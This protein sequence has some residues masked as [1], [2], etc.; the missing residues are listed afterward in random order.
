MTE[1][2][3]TV[4]ADM[5][6][7]ERERYE[8]LLIELGELR[9]LKELVHEYKSALLDKDKELKKKDQELEEIKEILLE[10]EWKDYELEQT[11]TRLKEL[12][13]EIERIMTAKSFWRR[14]LGS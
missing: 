14:L 2:S 1:R 9:K 8:R 12:E 6:M 13:G 11:Q 7:V 5:V 3:D 4:R 10:T